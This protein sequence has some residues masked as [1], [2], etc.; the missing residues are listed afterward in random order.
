MSNTTFNA[1]RLLRLSG[2]SG[3]MITVFVTG[4]SAIKLSLHVTAQGH[5]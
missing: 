5:R 4:S 1:N 2:L 3:H